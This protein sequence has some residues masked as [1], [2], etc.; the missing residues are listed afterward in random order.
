MVKC[1]AWQNH[2]RSALL[3]WGWRLWLQPAC[4]FL[5]V[6]TW[7]LKGRGTESIQSG[8]DVISSTLATSSDGL[9]AIG[10]SLEAISDSL[11]SLQ[12]AAQSAGGAI[13]SQAD[14]LQ[15][16]S[17]LF[18]KDLPQAMTG[19]QTAMIGAQA[20]AKE[21]EDTLTVLTSNP[22]FAATPY[23]PPVLLSTALS[24]VAGGLGALPAP[25][26]AVGGNLATNSGDLSTLEA[27]LTNFAASLEQLRGKLDEAH[28]VVARYQHELDRLGARLSWLRAGV[29]KWVRWMAWGISFILSWLGILQFFSL[30]RGLRWMMRVH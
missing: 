27:T 14:S 5:L 21:V 19:A 30:G 8:L 2:L 13:H 12:N 6:Q 28:T 17:T 26:Q 22:A 24:G 11:K 18:S 9:T 10:Q 20:G 25:M 29:P 15:A 16:L 1:E 7:R 23:N 4:C 3:A